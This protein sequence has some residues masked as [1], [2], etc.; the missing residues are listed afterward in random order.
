MI[1]S[2][3]M[4]ISTIALAL[5]F[6]PILFNL[7]LNYV[8]FNWGFR[9]GIAPMPPDVEETAL[10]GD[11]IVNVFVYAVLIAFV[12]LLLR[13]SR[14]TVEDLG[15][16]SRNW[17]SAVAVGLLV[18]GMVVGVFN[19]AVRMTREKASR[20]LESRGSAGTQYAIQ[21]LCSFAG[22]SWRAFC[23][24]GLIRLEL[25]AWLAVLIVAAAWGCAQLTRNLPSVI[26]SASFGVLA[27]FL[28]IGTGSFFA[29][30]SLNLVTG[31]T[32]I[33]RVRRASS[34]PDNPGR[35]AQK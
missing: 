32:Y 34:G 18:G 3:D 8:R 23:I 11:R 26:G 7:P 19:L 17:M 2:N 9:R 4:G 28:F 5:V 24:I 6:Y 25:S 13:H 30:L 12:F 14:I 27:G 1:E 20:K 16:S 35:V 33:Y 22:E 29:P 31:G 21:I 10:A 15:L